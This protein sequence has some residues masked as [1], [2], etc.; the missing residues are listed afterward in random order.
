MPA[1]KKIQSIIL[2][3]PEQAEQLDRLHKKTRVPKQ[4]YLREELKK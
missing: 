1:T 3:E 4:V 2:L